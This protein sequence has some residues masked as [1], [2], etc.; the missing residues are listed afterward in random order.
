MPD[1]LLESEYKIPVIVKTHFIC[2]METK[3]NTIKN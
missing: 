1:H 2:G 3:A